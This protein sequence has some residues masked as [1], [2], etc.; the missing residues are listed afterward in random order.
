MKIYKVVAMLALL[1]GL[2]PVRVAS[3]TLCSGDQ[4]GYPGNG[5]PLSQFAAVQ[6]DLDGTTVVVSGRSNIWHSSGH[7]SPCAGTLHM[8]LWLESNTCLTHEPDFPIT[9]ATPHYQNQSIRCS[10][11]ACSVLYHPRMSQW[12]GSD[13]PDIDNGVLD[14]SGV[15]VPCDE[16]G[17]GIYDDTDCDDHFYDTSN[18]CDYESFCG[19]TDED[20]RSCE[21]Q[22]D[23]HWYD[24]YEWGPGTDPVCECE[25]GASPIMLNLDTGSIRLTGFAHGV[26]FD[27]SGSGVPWLI[28]WTQANTRVGFLALDR[29]GD[30]LITS[31][32]ELFGTVT[33][34][35][36]LQP[37][38]QRNGFRALGV[39]DD[40][41]RGGNADGIISAAD[42]IFSQLRLWIDS[43]HDGISQPSELLSLPQAGIRAIS[44][45]YTRMRY[46]DTFG[47]Q[48][49]FKS[50][51]TMSSGTSR[52][53]RE[54]VD[55]FLGYAK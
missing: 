16:D 30:G 3:A 39:F 35:P 7:T 5:N 43:N 53:R 36:P 37:R 6:A 14:N 34:Q 1:G 15:R 40:P 24:Y 54:A 31:G 25:A 38:E 12:W 50:G 11:L 2:G 45:H 10:G 33:D 18:A 28:G 27:L 51:V 55:V 44:L 49:R 48:F 19:V 21:N 22:Q 52:D 23:A 32:K 20:V 13:D 9:Y 26:S 47:N 4:W 29:D 42:A 46:T 41:A 17:D 8:D